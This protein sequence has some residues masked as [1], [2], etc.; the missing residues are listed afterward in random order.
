M[1]QAFLVIQF[2]TYLLSLAEERIK[3]YV[4]PSYVVLAI[5]L[6]LCI[7][8]RKIGIDNDSEHYEMYYNNYDDKL[9]MISVEPSFRWLAHFLNY[10]T[11]DVHAI[12]LVYAAIAVTIKFIAFKKLFDNRFLPI[13]VYMGYTLIMQEMTQIRAGVV[14][15]LVL[16][17][18]IPLSEGRKKVTFLI[19]C[20]CCFIHYSAIALFPMLFLNNKDMSMRKRLIW[21]SIIPAAYIMHLCGLNVVLNLPIPYLGDKLQSYQTLRDKGILGSDINV[22]NAVLLVTIFTYYYVMYFY[23][24]IIAYNKYLPIMLKMTGISVVIFVI[25]S[26]VPVLAY[27]ISDLY[28]MT[29]ILL[30]SCIAY[31]IKPNWLART[32]VYVV[33]LSLFLIN[34][35]FTKLLHP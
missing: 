12:L 7:G 9:L 15:G 10:F 8:L 21:A 30:F 2:I 25:M 32:L 28:G 11:G 26:F 3:K 27:R 4:K 23:D 13:I 18:L 20:L 35:F 5:I 33:G 24:T 1:I 14:G 19:L 29:N 6:I 34:V 17:S 22:F 16:L 31:T